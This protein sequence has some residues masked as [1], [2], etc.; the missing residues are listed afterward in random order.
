[1][2]LPLLWVIDGFSATLMGLSP[3]KL[4]VSYCQWG[5]DKFYH[6]GYYFTIDCTSKVI[7][8]ENLLYLL[9]FYNR[10]NL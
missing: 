1:M 7:T 8:R 5:R 2:G 10:L 4:N 6:I 3:D 9:L